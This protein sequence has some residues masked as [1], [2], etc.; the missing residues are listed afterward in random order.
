[1]S[2]E[3]D[4]MERGSAMEQAQAMFD[5]IANGDI[6]AVESMLA[7]EPT[8]AVARNDQGISAVLVA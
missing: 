5:A 4:Q 1:M 3:M 6:S 8:L 2:R 7:Q